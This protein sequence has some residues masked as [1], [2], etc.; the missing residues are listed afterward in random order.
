MNLVKESYNEHDFSL[1]E[2]DASVA[3]IQN[4]EDLIKIQKKNN[5]DV[6]T[7]ILKISNNFL[8]QFSSAA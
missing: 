4:Y 8:R 3:I 1:C 7:K 6:Y 2:S 5:K